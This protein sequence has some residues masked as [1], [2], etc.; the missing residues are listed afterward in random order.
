MTDLNAEWVQRIIKLG[1]IE[2]KKRVLQII[3]SV[4]DSYERDRREMKAHQSDLSLVAEFVQ[5][6]SDLDALLRDEK[7]TFKLAEAVVKASRK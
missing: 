4:A 1:L 3:G 6:Y 7:A 5:R 2:E